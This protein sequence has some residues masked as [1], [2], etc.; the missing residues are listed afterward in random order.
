MVYILVLLFCLLVIK[1]ILKT[2]QSV[3]PLLGSP[4][5][6]EFETSFG[7]CPCQSTAI[8]LVI[9]CR[10]RALQHLCGSAFGHS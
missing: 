1:I 8:Y 9:D 3:K 10:V 2:V 6:S 7:S 4:G 5:I